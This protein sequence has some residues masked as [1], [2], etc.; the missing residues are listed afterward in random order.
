[1]PSI[2]MEQHF[3]N[4]KWD[5]WKRFHVVDARYHMTLF[6]TGE[7]IVNSYGKYDPDRR[8]RTT[9]W[10]VRFMLHTDIDEILKRLYTDKERTKPIRKAW[11]DNGLY[12]ADMER[13]QV[14]CLNHSAHNKKPIPGVPDWF[15]RTYFRAYCGG[16]GSDWI[17]VSNCK[18]RKPITFA[19][20]QKEHLDH[21][22]AA[23]MAA[24]RLGV[25]PQVVWQVPETEEDVERRGC[26]DHG[27]AVPQMF[28]FRNFE[29]LTLRE[30][31]YIARNGW[32]PAK[33]E[34]EEPCFWIGAKEGF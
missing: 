15:L 21:L 6:D 2:N 31:I 20:E 25:L 26:I 29:Q 9:S 14:V 33:E 13:N 22:R 11:L 16:A 5:L 24:D 30:K 7:V 10:G 32:A 27:Y 3:Q 23:C 8:R 28:L 17:S 1:M 34:H 4:P 19:R 18:Y 12:M